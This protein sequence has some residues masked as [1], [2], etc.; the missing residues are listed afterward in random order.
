MLDPR[1]PVGRDPTP[2]EA[3][4]GLFRYAPVVEFDPKWII[5]HQREVLGMKKV[6]TSPALLESTSLVFAYGLDIFG[7][8]VTPS[9]AFDILGHGFGKLQLVGTM[10]ALGAGV[11]FL[12]PMVSLNF[13]LLGIRLL[14]RVCRYVGSR[15]IQDGKYSRLTIALEMYSRRVIC[16]TNRIGNMMEAVIM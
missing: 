14:T 6:I 16:M 11:A 5:T 13:A 4:E 8:R 2:A 12:A 1:R 15:S 3:E 10:L 9:L 7:T